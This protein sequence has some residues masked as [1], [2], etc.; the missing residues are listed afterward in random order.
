MENLKNGKLIEKW[1]AHWVAYVDKNMNCVQFPHTALVA[2]PLA[3]FRVP[4][5]SELLSLSVVF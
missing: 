3:R 1:H 5:R 4:D 2:S